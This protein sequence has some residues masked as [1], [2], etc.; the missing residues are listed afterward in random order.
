MPIALSNTANKILMMTYQSAPAAWRQFAAV[1]ST[2]DFKD[3]TGVRPTFNN[4]LQQ[5]APGGEI[6]HADYSEETYKWRVDTFARML[7][8]DRRDFVNDDLGAFSEVIPS[9][10]KSAARSLS[11]LVAKTILANVGNG[12]AFWTL[13]R[14]NYHEGA[15]SVLSAASLAI[16]IRLLRQM[17]DGEGNLLDLQPAVL[18]VP[19]EWNGPPANC[20]SRR[21]SCALRP[22]ACR[23]ET[24][25]RDSWRWRLSRGFRIRRSSATAQSRGISSRI[26][27]TRLSWSGFWMDNS[28]LP[29]RRSGSTPRSTSWCIRS[30]F[31]TILEVHLPTS[32]PRSRARVLREPWGRSRCCD[33]IAPSGR[34]EELTGR[35]ARPGVPPVKL[36]DWNNQDT[37]EE[38]RNYKCGYCGLNVGARTGYGRKHIPEP[39]QPNKFNLHQWIALCPNCAKPSFWDSGKQVPGPTFG[40]D[41]KHV[42]PDVDGLY[43]E[44][45]NCMAVFAYTAG[46]MA[47]RKILMNV[48]VFLRAPQNQSFAQYVDYMASQG[49][50]PPNGRP[51]V[52]HIRSKGNEAN[53]E[54]PLLRKR[55]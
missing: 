39:K 41:V 25:T 3:N 28:G 32:G 23:P 36:T 14:L 50:V 20:W 27:R 13:A 26:R 37:Y 16:S 17:K 15:G 47:C 8:I 53:H 2:A 54:I 10:A 6:E 11:N 44:A 4:T 42:P 22:T 48:A 51:W 45:R 9:F 1:K 19:P 21:R 30:G 12:V 29:S 5:L 46:S 49:Y 18:V 24:S 35:A 52:D 34:P 33:R 40:E 43:S 7:G 55:T 31:T 38:A